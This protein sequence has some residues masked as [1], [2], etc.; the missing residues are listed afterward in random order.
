[1]SEFERLLELPSDETKVWSMFRVGVLA[2]RPVTREE[3][4]ASMVQGNYPWFVVKG[5]EVDDATC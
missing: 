2:D 1:M 5:F 4:V 3:M